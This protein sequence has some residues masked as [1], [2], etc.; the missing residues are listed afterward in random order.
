MLLGPHTALPVAARAVKGLAA[1]I[2]RVYRFDGAATRLI[3]RAMSAEEKAAQDNAHL[4]DKE[5]PTMYVR[6]SMQTI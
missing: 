1:P 5:P 4:A 3:T 6:S 2:H